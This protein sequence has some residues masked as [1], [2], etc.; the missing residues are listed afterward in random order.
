VKTVTFY[1]DHFSTTP[2][3]DAINDVLGHDLAAWLLEGL[4]ARGYE[5]DDIIGEDYGYGFWLLVEETSIW[6][7]A[8]QYEPPGYEGHAHSRWLVDV[9]TDAGCLWL[10]RPRR[11]RLTPEKLRDLT[12]DIHTL[13]L[14]DSSITGIEWWVQDVRVGNPLPEP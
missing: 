12:R 7:N 3:P 11:K 4:R 5:A 1:T 6:I 13:L 14:T 2:L 8:T 10:Y 9:S